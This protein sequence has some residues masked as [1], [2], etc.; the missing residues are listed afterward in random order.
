VP[1]TPSPLLD[2][3]VAPVTPTAI[4]TTAPP[5]EENQVLLEVAPPV[6]APKAYRN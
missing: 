4:T 2:V 3:V 6:Q 1:A 5:E